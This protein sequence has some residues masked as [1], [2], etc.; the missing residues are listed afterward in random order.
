MAKRKM[1]VDRE[2]SKKFKK[3]IGTISKWAKRII[4]VG[5]CITITRIA[6]HFIYN[7]LTNPAM[8][9]GVSHNYVSYVEPF[10]HYTLSIVDTTDENKPF[11]MVGNVDMG[12]FLVFTE[13]DGDA[14]LV[15]SVDWDQQV[16]DAQNENTIYSRE[17]LASGT[18]VELRKSDLFNDILEKGE[19]EKRIG[20]NGITYNVSV[21][22]DDLNSLLDSNRYTQEKE[23]QK[24]KEK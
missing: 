1:K 3:V 24:V 21:T 13:S 11:D 23:L 4:I 7:S 16:H 2:G 18:L 10:T 12:Y 17:D 5:A 8:Q 9:S 20:I 6:G 15:R 22:D 19:L 14:H